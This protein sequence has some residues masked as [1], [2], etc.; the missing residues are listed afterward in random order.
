MTSILGRF[1]LNVRFVTSSV[2]KWITAA[3]LA[4]IAGGLATLIRRCRARPAEPEPMADEPEP[5]H[6]SMARAVLARSH[7]VHPELAG[8]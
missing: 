7:D 8:A 5:P 4:L 2:T 6:L 1:A 3:G